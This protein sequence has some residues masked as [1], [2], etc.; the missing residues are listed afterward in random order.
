MAHHSA[1]LKTEGARNFCCGAKGGIAVDSRSRLAVRKK[2]NR[3]ESHFSEK[4]MK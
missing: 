1:N 4:C 3:R 2:L